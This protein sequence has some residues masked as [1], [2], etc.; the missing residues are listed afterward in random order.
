[1]T[2]TN[3]LISLLGLEEHA[4]RAATARELAFVMVND[5]R[6]VIQYRQA[7]LITEDCRVQAV[8]GVAEVEGNAPFTLWLQ[9][10]CR[11]FDFD[12]PRAIGPDDVLAADA[13]EWSEWLPLQA[14]WLPLPGRD[15]KRQG[16]LLL[17]R[18]EAWD[19]GEIALAAHAVGTFAHAWAAL[20]RPS[21][22][23]T[24]R[25]R[26]TAIPKWR[27]K[28]A[29]AIVLL[30]LFPVRLSV[31]AP[32]EIVARDPAVIRS[33]LDGV[34]ER[35]LVRPNQV[36]TEGEVLLELD[37][38][39]LTGKLEVAKKALSTAQAE[40]DQTTQQAFFDAKAKGQLAVFKARIDERQADLAQLEDLLARA[41]VKAPR[42]GVAVLDDPAEWQGRPVGVGERIMA[43][44]APD[45][46]EIEAWLAPADIIELE[47]GGPVTAFLNAAPLSPVTARLLYVAYEAVPQADGAPGHR[48]RAKLEP[49]QTAPRLGLKGTARLDGHRV[50]LIYWLLRRP[51][52]VVRGYLGL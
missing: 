22:L 19:E 34:V 24:W 4:R 46:T 39:T 51:L 28:V 52:G 2:E 48:V 1:M 13:A 26:L 16:G 17:A 21:P 50:P 23:S 35:V 20:H 38:T 10:I 47:A 8:S 36:V 29:A 43:V 6:Q 5:T 44:A 25:Q 41:V 27:L 33:P 45:D 42:A 11:R 31:L 49:G 32:A 14:L 12:A 18:D 40:T 7:A 15:G 9:R 37:R 3:P 30:L